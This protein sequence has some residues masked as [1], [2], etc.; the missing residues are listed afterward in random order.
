MVT[1][2]P[3][4]FVVI[5]GMKTA[6]KNEFK[7][8]WGLLEITPEYRK[9]L[10]EI[11][12]AYWENRSNAEEY[13]EQVH[14]VFLNACR[15]GHV[16]L[17]QEAV[18]RGG[19]PTIARITGIERKYIKYAISDNGLPLFYDFRHACIVSI[20]DDIEVIMKLYD[21]SRPFLTVRWPKAVRIQEMI[22]TS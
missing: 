14:M 20:G 3:C 12:N 6:Q 8:E 21:F 4:V 10:A 11:V 19:I 13:R 16:K 2:F 5:L 22:S 1:D 9:Q 17:P 15:H 18:I 7:V